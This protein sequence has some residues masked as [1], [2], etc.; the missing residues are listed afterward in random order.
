MPKNIDDMKRNGIE[1]VFIDSNSAPLHVIYIFLCNYYVI[2]IRALIIGMDKIFDDCR[3][4]FLELLN[5]GLA[6]S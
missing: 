4:S 6:P 3:L 2:F 5:W 1:T